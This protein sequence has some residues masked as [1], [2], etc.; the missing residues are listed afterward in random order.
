MNSKY[1]FLNI[2]DSNQLL[3]ITTDNPNQSILD[4]Y[5][6]FQTDSYLGVNYNI[7]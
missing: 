2:T 5:I 4:P 3:N 1:D 7:K 6:P